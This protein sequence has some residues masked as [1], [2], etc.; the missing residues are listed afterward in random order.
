MGRSLTCPFEANTSYPLPRY[1]LMVFAF[2]G[3]STMTSVLA[4]T[5][6]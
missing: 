1:F 3:D 5:T 2:A 4:I 6:F